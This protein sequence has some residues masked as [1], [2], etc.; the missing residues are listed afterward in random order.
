MEEEYASKD[1]SDYIDAFRRRMV[2]ITVIAASIFIL[3]LVVALVWP[4]TYRSTATI[5]IE[6]Q[7]IPSDLV[8]STITSFANQRIQ[9]IKARVMTRQNL[10]EIIKKYDFM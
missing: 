9:T 8:R 10:M 1:L 5:L 4:P 3:S 7:E 2:S 6:G